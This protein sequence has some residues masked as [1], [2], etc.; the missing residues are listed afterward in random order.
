MR[1]LGLLCGALV[2]LGCGGGDAE[3]GGGEGGTAG[4]GGGG[5]GDGGGEPCP[6]PQVL[7]AGTCVTPGVPVAGCAP[8]FEHDGDLGCVAVMPEQPCGDGLVA[9]P[10]DTECRDL[11]PCLDGTFSDL[12]TDNT[13]QFV[14][15]SYGGGDS[16]GSQAKPWVTIGEGIAAATSGAIVA[17]AAGSYPED[18]RIEDKSVELW[19]Q[20]ASLV[21]I[22][23]QTAQAA[24]WIQGGAATGSEVHNLAVVGDDVGVVVISASDVLVEGVWVHDT[25]SVGINTADAMGPVSLTVRASLVERAA[26]L[27]IHVIGGSALVEGT[28]V[29]DTQPNPDDLR[30][31]RGIEVVRSLYTTIDSDLTISG[32]VVERNHDLGVN[33]G[34][35]TAT[36]DGTLIRD[37]L[38]QVADQEGG[39]GI[40]A[41][42]VRFQGET[43]GGSA[44][45]VISGTVVERSTEIGIFIAASE[46]EIRQTTVRDVAPSAVDGRFGRGIE[47]GGQL[48][49]A[50]PVAVR[51]SLL[52]A[53]TLIDRVHDGGLVCCDC[54]GAIDLLAIRDVEARPF[55]DAFGDG[56]VL[57]AQADGT[58]A[59]VTSTRVQNSA[60]AGV[61]VF[62]SHLELGE[63]VLECNTFPLN[64]EM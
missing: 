24:L 19:G 13:T 57:F 36:I 38:T 4:E 31:G 35:G 7:K 49:G 43:S 58:R 44:S 62:G 26:R 1:R 3:P 42:A 20:C 40:N 10:G 21:E 16:D 14:D 18:V 51:S 50:D 52:V 41:Q 46:A 8:G 59:T 37:T 6:A 30:H 61:G 28:T 2:I 27:G 63:V 33:I 64:G 48:F 25:A 60:R 39:R 5:G 47:G 23:G 11:T 54:E 12:P 29:R 55:D 15:G 53:E 45:L 32:S 34:G 56:I 22:R 17:V 9:L